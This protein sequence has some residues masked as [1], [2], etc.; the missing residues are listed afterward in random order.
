MW[1]FFCALIQVIYVSV[2][3]DE[4]HYVLGTRNQ[5]SLP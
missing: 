3:T 1:C 2:D 4:R 5:V